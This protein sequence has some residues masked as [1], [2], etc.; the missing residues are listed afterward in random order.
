MENEQMFERTVKP[1]LD[2]R[3][4]P[5]PTQWAFL[6]LHLFAMFGSTV[7]TILNASTYISI[8]C[9]RYWT[10]IYILITR[11]KIPLI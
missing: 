1:V 7:Y 10:L 6:S 5:K 11:A 2:V 8:T 3:D 9:V 4:K